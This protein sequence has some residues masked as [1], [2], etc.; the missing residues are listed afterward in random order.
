MFTA[1]ASVFAFE[2][3]LFFLVAASFRAVHRP[4]LLLVSLAESPRLGFGQSVSRALGQIIINSGL[5]MR[6]CCSVSIQRSIRSSSASIGAAPCRQSEEIGYESM[7]VPSARDSSALRESLRKHL[8]QMF[9][10][11]FLNAADRSNQTNALGVCARRLG[12]IHVHGN[13][14]VVVTAADSGFSS[15]DSRECSFSSRQLDEPN[16]LGISIMQGATPPP[17]PSPI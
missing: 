10:I 4:R 11:F 1:E 5:Q 16:L 12:F 9:F 7:C 3:F 17:L 8:P 15:S 2:T 13:A 14:K 6:I